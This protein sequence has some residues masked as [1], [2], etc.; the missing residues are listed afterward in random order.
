MACESSPVIILVRPQMGE[1]IGAAARAMAN[2]GLSRLRIVAPRDGWPN[3]QAIATAS[4]AAHL[5]NS[6]EIFP[7]IESALADITRAYA[8]T[9]RLRE[10][11]KPVADARETIAEIKR[12]S[13][14]SQEKC[15]ILFGAE[16]SGLSNEEVSWC[17]AVINIPTAPEYSSLNLAQSVVIVAYEWHMLGGGSDGNSAVKHAV[18]QDSER[19]IPE[20]D[21]SQQSAPLA[22]YDYLFRQLEN[23]LEKAQFFKVPEKKPGMMLNIKTMLLRGNFTEQEIRTF[24]GI[25]KAM[26]GNN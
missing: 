21:I 18:K 9:A 5:L 19:T 3:K 6:A 2:F 4:G 11:A 25:L 15:A 1:N 24:H 10:M 20:A 16:R 26:A 23:Y 13:G 14:N 8:A 22:Q 12:I 17:Q 7:D